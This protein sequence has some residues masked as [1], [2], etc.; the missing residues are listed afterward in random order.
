MLV[1][2]VAI[3]FDVAA[4]LGEMEAAVVT[5]P[6]GP[7]TAFFV[8]LYASVL[9]TCVCT[10]PTGAVLLRWSWR[11]QPLT[12]SLWERIDA[13]GFRNLAR[14]RACLCQRVPG[15]SGFGQPQLLV[16]RSTTSF[17]LPCSKS[18]RCPGRMK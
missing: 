17:R 10:S 5:S 6:G 7:L 16:S 14:R 3:T 9:V 2:P 13:G 8:P 1:L 12:H 15:A 11:S 18:T 4:G